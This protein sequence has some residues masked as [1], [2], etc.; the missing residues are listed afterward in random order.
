[1]Y[2]TNYITIKTINSHC[3]VVYSHVREGV[4]IDTTVFSYDTPVLRVDNESNIHRLWSGY[5]K[6]TINDI[7]KSVNVNMNKLK[8]D[9]M[10]IE[11]V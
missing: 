5:S 9:S 10:E 11:E 3:T 7:N 6:T 8:W 1:M 4:G 2:T